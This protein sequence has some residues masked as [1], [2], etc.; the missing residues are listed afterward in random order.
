MQ[1]LK[2]QKRFNDRDR[3]VNAHRV[4]QS[5]AKLCLFSV[6]NNTCT[7]TYDEYMTVC[8]AATM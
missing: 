4:E 7:S 5:K 8:E 3:L 1:L 2:G 6:V